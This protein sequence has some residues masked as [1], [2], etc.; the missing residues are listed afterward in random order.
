MVSGYHIEYVFYMLDCAP[1][2]RVHRLFWKHG[3]WQTELW[4]HIFFFN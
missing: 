1:V 3:D 4:D 2:S